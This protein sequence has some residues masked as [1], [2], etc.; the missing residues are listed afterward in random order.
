MACTPAWPG[1]GQSCRLP[2][3]GSEALALW[4]SRVCQLVNIFSLNIDRDLNHKSLYIFSVS[5]T[6]NMWQEMQYSTVEQI[7]LSLTLHKNEQMGL[8][9]YLLTC[10]NI[11]ARFRFY[12][13]F[14]G[15][16]SILKYTES[17]RASIMYNLYSTRH[18]KNQ[19]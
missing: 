7:F 3:T 13:M 6:N 4:Q 15:V 2:E 18:N 9:Y 19:I 16:K 14:N 5:K 10:V 12:F 11:L 1:Q 17:Y 8:D